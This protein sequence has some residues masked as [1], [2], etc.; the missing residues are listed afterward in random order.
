MQKTM[1]QTVQGN[2]GGASDMQDISNIV[3]SVKA[4]IAHIKT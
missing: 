4:D 2:N 1:Q 3:K